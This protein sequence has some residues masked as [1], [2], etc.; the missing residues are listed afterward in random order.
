VPFLRRGDLLPEIAA[1]PP[2][3][4]SRAL[5]AALGRREAPAVNT[6]LGGEPAPVWAEALGANVLDVDGN[7]YLDFTSGFGVASVGHRHP[8]VVAAVA[9]QAAK[10]LHGMADVAAH[11]ARVALAERLG[12][13]AP[14]DDAA[15]Y[16]AVSGSDAIEIALKT[17]L[18]ATGRPGV[19]A[20]TGA[21]HGLSPGALAA[22]SRA[23]FRAPFQLHLHPHVARAAYGAR[24]AELEDA[25]R[26]FAGRLGAVLVE[27]LLGREGIV[28]APAGWLE[29]LAA[30]ARR[31]GALF[32]LDEV[33]TGF[34]RTGRL[35]A[36]EHHGVVPDLLCCGKAL[37]GGL[38][39]GAVLGRR[40]LLARWPGDG[41]ALHTGTFLAH[42]LSCAA[43]LAALDVIADEGLVERSA[44]LGAVIG[45]RIGGW[46]GLHSAVAA[47]RG[48]G[49]AWAIVLHD[50]GLAARAQRAALG[51]GLLLLRGGPGGSVLQIVPPLVISE[52]QLAAGLAILERALDD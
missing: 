50:A 15:V 7:R 17:A 31:E 47:V 5:S 13:L 42:P 8:R 22:T 49:M 26:P 51:A 37:G 32:V 9:A 36:A 40:D 25:A 11:P 16:F 20:F 14:I 35:F 30:L 38:P 44:A 23:A 48:Q 46:P 10:L 52:A 4:R 28:P 21:Y 24:G 33:F 18:L 12:G 19:L 39:I 29:E 41:E 34:G 6:L 1:S 43:S 3:P 27:P 45:A 2:G